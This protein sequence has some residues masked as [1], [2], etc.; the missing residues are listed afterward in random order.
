LYRLDIGGMNEKEA[1][2]GWQW[3]ACTSGLWGTMVRYRIG[4]NKVGVEWIKKA[5]IGPDGLEP[6]E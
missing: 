5:P 3:M 1:I 2:R 4:K 6:N